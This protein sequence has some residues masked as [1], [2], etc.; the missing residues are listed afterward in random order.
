MKLVPPWSAWERGETLKVSVASELEWKKEPVKMG[1][2]KIEDQFLGRN[3][4]PEHPKGSLHPPPGAVPS[5]RKGSF[6][7][8]GT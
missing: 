8:S 3:R 2:Q 1:S 6:V 7:R 5:E 4:G